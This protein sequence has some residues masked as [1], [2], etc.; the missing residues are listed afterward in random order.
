[1][2]LTAQALV[3]KILVLTSN[4]SRKDL[5]QTQPKLT[6]VDLYTQGDSRTKGNILRGN[7]SFC[8]SV[9]NLL[10]SSLLSKNLK[11]KIY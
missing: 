9:Q 10:S 5:Q 3:N 2:I 11:I 6:S 1:V 4:G 7:M 8:H